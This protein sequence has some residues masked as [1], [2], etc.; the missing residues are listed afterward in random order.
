[1]IE[2]WQATHAAESFDA[3][4]GHR[5]AAAEQ[6]ERAR[7]HLA[8]ADGVSEIPRNVGVL[9][10]VVAELDAADVAIDLADELLDELDALDVDLAAALRDAPAAVAGARTDLSLIHI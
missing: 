7:Q 8:T 9:R 5:S 3:V 6:L 4:L 2:A 10:D 1:M